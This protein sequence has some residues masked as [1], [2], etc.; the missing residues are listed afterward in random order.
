[1]SVSQPSCASAACFRAGVGITL[2][3][4][5][6]VVFAELAW[7]PALMIQAEDRAHRLGQQH[8]VRRGGEGWGW[9][10]RQVAGRNLEPALGN[11]HAA[12]SAAPLH[13]FRLLLLLLLHAEPVEAAC[14]LF[15]QSQVLM[16][17]PSLPRPAGR[18]T[19]TTAWPLAAAT[20]SCGR[21]RNASWAR[22]DV[23][24][25]PSGF[26]LRDCC[27]GRLSAGGVEGCCL[28]VPLSACTCRAGPA[29]GAER[30]CPDAAAHALCPWRSWL[31]FRSALQ[32]LLLTV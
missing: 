13:G 4:S 14:D 8:Q 6:T 26:A 11:L 24:S 27:G 18:S 25:A 30:R 5:H 32:L 29:S 22:C 28:L 19:C 21:W 10:T 15:F 17:L 2:T 7:S 20:T 1:M 31:L 3:A 23:C 16:I 9:G 12:A